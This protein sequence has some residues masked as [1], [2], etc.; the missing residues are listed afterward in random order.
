MNGPFRGARVGR[1][2]TILLGA[3]VA[4]IFAAAAFA[5][6]G[7][8][9]WLFD[10]FSHFRWHYVAAA[11]VIAP[12]ALWR[13]AR[14]LALAAV[15]AGAAHVPALLERPARIAPASPAGPVELSVMTAN[16]W[17]RS[18]KLDNLLGR[19]KVADPDI[20]VLQEVYGPW[21]RAIETL[22]IHYPHIAP[23]E[24]R[25]SGIVILSRHPI[26]SSRSAEFAVT[27]DIDFKGRRIRLAGI[28]MPTPLS[29]AKWRA[30]QS[31][32]NGLAEDA[33]AAGIPYIA[34]GDF[35]LTPYSP[36]FAR[37]L[38]ASGLRRVPLGGVWPATWPAASGLKYGGPLWRG[39]EIDH[40]LVSR[41]FT[42]VSLFRGPDI[43]SDHFPVHALLK[44]LP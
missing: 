3:A 25:E 23:A 16:V 13:R 4:A 11:A 8:R 28:H 44:F 15:L 19:I 6:F 41:A 40:V 10:V 17:W 31:A 24:W 34:A 26:Q 18:D 12:L 32:F 7:E 30:Q 29:A 20:V 39:L 1:A 21:H 38:D 43:G 5:E 33:R 27:A 37:L 22:R 14:W 35:N 9:W 42:A 2:G 36:R